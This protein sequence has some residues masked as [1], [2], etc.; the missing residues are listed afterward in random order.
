MTTMPRELLLLRHARS[1][2]SVSCDDFHR[3]LQTR[4]NAT[5]S[6]WEAG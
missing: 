2:W 4:A 3:P 1:D 6:A 5:P